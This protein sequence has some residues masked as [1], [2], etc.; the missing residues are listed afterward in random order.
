MEVRFRSSKGSL[1]SGGVNQPT[2]FTE[3]RESHQSMEDNY[4]SW[5]YY[6]IALFHISVELDD[7]FPPYFRQQEYS[8]HVGLRSKPTC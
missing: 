1:L 2:R 8:A 7:K 6:S 5:G 3:G 4:A